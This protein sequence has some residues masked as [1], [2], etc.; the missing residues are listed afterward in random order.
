MY[1]CWN[2]AGSKCLV[3]LKT[4]QKWVVYDCPV[5]NE[6]YTR[7]S[8]NWVCIEEKKEQEMVSSMAYIEEDLIRLYQVRKEH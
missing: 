6:F 7:L 2:T 1:A 4:F 3:I 8:Y 5:G